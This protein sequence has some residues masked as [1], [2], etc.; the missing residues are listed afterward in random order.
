MKRR[1]II[2]LA[3]GLATSNTLF[4]QPGTIT[5]YKEFTGYAVSQRGDTA[6]VL[7]SFFD[8]RLHKYLVVDPYSLRTSLVESSGVKA[9]RLKRPRLLELFGNS[10]YVR[11]LK[12][13]EYTSEKVK[14]AGVRR[15]QR[16]AGGVDLTIDLCPSMLPLDREFFVELVKS[17]SMVQKPVPMAISVTG[18][19]MKGH[20]ADFTWLLDRVKSGEID[21]TWINHSYSHRVDKEL[22]LNEN[23]LLEKGTDIPNEILRTEITMLERGV[24]PSPFFRFPGLVSDKMV[25]DTVL[26]FGLIPIGT[27]AWIA[28]KQFPKLGSIVLVHANGNEPL[29]LKKFQKLLETQRDSILA[30]KWMLYDLRE[31]VS[32]EEVSR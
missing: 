31:S 5:R 8:N 7:R 26:S 24:V 27:D 14:N 10:P 15:F 30:G 4:A 19:W 21:V 25:F 20:S 2:A 17:L 23:F 13:A 28:K 32:T 29:G 22:P 3:I 6:I 12:V 16:L 11:T 18:T 9:T 1:C